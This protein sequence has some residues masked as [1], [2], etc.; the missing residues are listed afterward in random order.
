MRRRQSASAV[1]FHKQVISSSG[2]ETCHW[3]VHVKA[4]FTLLLSFIQLNPRNPSSYP[5]LLC[6]NPGDYSVSYPVLSYPIRLYPI[7]NNLLI[8]PQICS[9]SVTNKQSASTT[10]KLTMCSYNVCLCFSKWSAWSSSL[11]KWLGP[12]KLPAW[13]QVIK[14]CLSCTALMKLTNQIRA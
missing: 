11:L 4:A 5:V 14:A 3:V 13:L 1:F 12:V 10:Q 7:P 6:L 9:L 8:F 2:G